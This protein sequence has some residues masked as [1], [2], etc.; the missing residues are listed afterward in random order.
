MGFI[1]FILRSV[2][3]YDAS[4]ICRFGQRIERNKRRQP[5]QQQQQQQQMQHGQV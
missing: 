4:N 2:T 3:V 1:A 5:R